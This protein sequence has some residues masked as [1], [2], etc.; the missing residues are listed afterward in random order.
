[1]IAIKSLADSQPRLYYLDWLRVLAFSL[2]I[3]SNTARV[4]GHEKWW[5]QNSVTSNE[6]DFVLIFFGAANDLQAQH[7]FVF[8]VVAAFVANRVGLGVLRQKLGDRAN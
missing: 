4:F 3:I 7:E 6:I 5:M 1:M 2:L 8:A